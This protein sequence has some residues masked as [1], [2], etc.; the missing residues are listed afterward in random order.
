MGLVGSS[1]GVGVGQQLGAECLLGSR[2]GGHIYFYLLHGSL[3]TI[4]N[5]S[6]RK[7]QVSP[8]ETFLR[9]SKTQINLQLEEYRMYQAKV[10][11]QI[12]KAIASHVSRTRI[13]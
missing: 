13:T 9:L 10:Q 2:K 5:M 6:V 7:M 8:A 3:R 12:S 1:L 4:I 11:Q